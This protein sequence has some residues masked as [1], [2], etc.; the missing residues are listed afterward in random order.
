MY[1]IGNDQTRLC[2]VVSRRSSLGILL[3][4]AQAC[5]WQAAEVLLIAGVLGI[6]VGALRLVCDDMA[7]L[8]VRRQRIEQKVQAIDND[9]SRMAVEINLYRT[10]GFQT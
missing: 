8:Q 6:S 2:I 9:L 7:D 5:L 1:Q 10:E 4:F 3:V